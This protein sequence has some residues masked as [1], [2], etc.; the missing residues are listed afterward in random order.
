MCFRRHLHHEDV[1]RCVFDLDF[2]SLAIYRSDGDHA[3]RLLFGNGLWHR[4]VG[5]RYYGGYPMQAAAIVKYKP[6]IV[7]P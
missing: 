3:F 7:L 5:S 2:T 4:I 1:A 6:R